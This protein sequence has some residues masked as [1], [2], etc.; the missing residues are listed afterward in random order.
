[1]RKFFYHLVGIV[2]LGF[3][4]STLINFVLS[5]MPFVVGGFIVML[6]LYGVLRAKKQW[7]DERFGLKKW[8]KAFASLF[9]WKKSITFYLIV[10]VAIG[11]AFDDM[12]KLMTITLFALAGSLVGTS[13]LWESIRPLVSRL[14]RRQVL[15]FGEACK[16]AW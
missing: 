1:M 15:S 3:M 2:I 7:N 6:P 14:K 10:G 12:V 5:F 16:K 11:F 9:H 13:L 8:T 4:V